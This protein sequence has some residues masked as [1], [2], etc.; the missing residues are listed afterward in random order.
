MNRRGFLLNPALGVTPGL[1]LTRSQAT[2]PEH[3]WGRCDWPSGPEVKDS[4]YQNP[5]PQYTPDAVIPGSDVI[6]VTTPS[7]DIVPK[8][9]MGL[10]VY[11]SG[12][13]GPPRSVAF[14][15]QVAA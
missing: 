2:I 10:L 3:S 11:V 15:F 1:T 5:F 9:G 12:N 14:C 4:L 7:T 6:M 8:P 13:T